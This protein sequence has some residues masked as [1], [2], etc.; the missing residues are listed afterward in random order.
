M[1]TGYQLDSFDTTGLRL[2]EKESFIKHFEGRA[3]FLDKTISSEDVERLANVAMKL[4]NRHYANKTASN[5]DQLNAVFNTTFDNDVNLDQ[6]ESS[7]CE[8]SLELFTLDY[9]N[10]RKQKTVNHNPGESGYNE[11]P[12]T[13]LEAFTR[14][15]AKNC[16]H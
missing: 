10:W 2:W 9:G 15:F 6:L 4:A 3:R 1:Y 7:N 14:D 8:S 13:S 11:K 5:L 16:L 12:K